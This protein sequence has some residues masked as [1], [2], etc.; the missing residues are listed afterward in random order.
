MEAL[1]S[2][3]GD[4]C[5]SW[6]TINLCRYLAETYEE[7]FIFAAGN[8][9]LTFSDQMSDVETAS[10]MSD[11]CINISDIYPFKNVTKQVRSKKFE[12]EKMMKSLSGDMIVSKF[13]E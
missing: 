8:S 9:G 1:S 13:G 5:H 7:E 11:V 4:I 3:S 2:N 12:A 10:M 6:S